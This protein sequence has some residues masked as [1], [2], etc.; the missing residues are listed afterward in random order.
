MSLNDLSFGLIRTNPK[1]SGNVKITVDSNQDIWLN[2]FNANPELSNNQFKKFRI[3]PTGFYPLDLYRFFLNGKVPASTVFETKQ[4]EISKGGKKDLVEQYDMFYTYGA[5][6]LNSKFYD[7]EVSLFAPLYLKKQIPKYFVIY[8]VPGPVTISN[9]TAVTLIEVGIEYKVLGSSNFTVTYNDVVYRSGDTFIGVTDI[10][11]FI[12]TSDNELY[13]LT[14]DDKVII[15]NENNYINDINDPSKLFDNVL[16]QGELVKTFDLRET[17]KIGQYIRNIINSPLYPIA[18]LEVNFGKDNLSHWHGISYKDGSFAKKGNFLYSELVK[19]TPLINFEEIITLGFERQ[20]LICA[21]LLNL[22][23]LFTDTTSDNWEINRYFGFYVDD[24]STG[25][26]LLDADKL[27]T[28]SLGINQLPIPKIFQ[29]IEPKFEGIFN[30]TN[31]DGIKVWANNLE[32]TFPTST[33]LSNPEFWW[34]KDN[35]NTFHNIK[36]ASTPVLDSTNYEF[37][38]TDKKLNIGQLTGFNRSVFDEKAFALKTKGRASVVLEIKESF[39]GYVNNSNYGEYIDLDVNYSLLRIMANPVPEWNVSQGGDHFVNLNF[40]VMP[41]DFPPVLANSNVVL[42]WFHPGTT[43]EETAK[44]I[45]NALNAYELKTFDAFAIGAKVYI[46]TKSL[47]SVGNTWFVN[48]NDKVDSLTKSGTKAIFTG[49]SDHTGSRVKIEKINPIIGDIFVKT[50][51]DWS[52]I[53]SVTPYLEEPI[54]INGV[55]QEF[56]DIE[57]YSILTITDVKETILIN[58]QNR[59]IGY[60]LWR[61]EVGIFSLYPIRDFDFDFHKSI[62]NKNLLHEIQKYYSVKPDTDGLLL[63]HIAYVVDGVDGDIIHYYGND[64]EPGQTFI[65]VQGVETGFS[66][67]SGT[68]TIRPAYYKNNP[69]SNE[70]KL[71]EFLGFSTLVD[72]FST[73]ETITSLAYKWF[74]GLLPNEYDYLKENTNKDLSLKSR[75]TPYINKWAFLDGTDIRNNPYRLNTNNVFGELNFSPSFVNQ[76]PNPNKFTHEWYYIDNLPIGVDKADLIDNLNYFE[77]KIDKTKLKQITSDYFSEYFRLTKMVGVD[78]HPQERWTEFRFNKASGFSETLF[79]GAKV[80]VKKIKNNKDIIK[81]DLSFQGYKFSV[82][83]TSKK[84]DT[85]IIEAPITYEVI[86]NKK[87]KTITIVITAILEDLR[88]CDDFIDY[89]N[90]EFT[91]IS[92]FNIIDG[93]PNLSWTPKSFLPKLDYLGLYTLA[94]KKAP[95]STSSG[96][97]YNVFDS[98]VSYAADI[99]LSFGLLLNKPVESE[100]VI[101]T[102]TIYDII[103]CDNDK[104]LINWGVNIYE[105]VRKITD[106]SQNF[107]FGDFVVPNMYKFVSTDVVF[108]NMSSIRNINTL[109]LKVLDSTYSSP[110]IGKNTLSRKT[111]STTPVKYIKGGLNFYSEIIKK[112]SFSFIQELLNNSSSL[113]TYSSIDENGNSIVSDF[114][115]N[116]LEPEIVSKTTTLTP[117]KDTDFPSELRILSN[118]GYDLEESNANN[119]V[120]R[121]SGYYQPIFKDL[122]LFKSKE[123]FEL[124][125]TSLNLTTNFGLINNFY[126]H[127]VS[128]RDIMKLAQNSKYDSVYPLINEISIDKKPLYIWQSNWDS[129]YHQ[130]Y[131]EAGVYTSQSGTRQMIEH[132][133]FLGSKIMKTPEKITINDFKSR[134]VT[135][136]ENFI[137][138]DLGDTEA[139]YTFT[140]ETIRIRVF[141]KKR[142]LRWMR[143]DGASNEFLKNILPEY[144]GGDLNSLNDDIDTY[145][146]TNIIELFNIDNIDMWVKSFKEVDNITLK[147][148][149]TEFNVIEKIQKGYKRKDNFNKNSI[150]KWVFEINYPIPTSNLTSIGIEFGIK[151][152]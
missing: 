93:S 57:K 108:K 39:V 65:K 53:L 62:Y 14:E 77:T 50:T 55:F 4:A 46:V 116:L 45:A 24:L 107:V 91:N 126:Y 109:L 90:D 150:S 148:V 36:P 68:P 106:A 32:G 120:L 124:E 140:N 136:I 7:E 20:S 27:K 141:A 18:P 151:R 35:T 16:K 89:Q 64:Y 152:I 130:F 17:S 87:F 67:S 112:L 104:T 70:K 44:G 6:A 49:G 86:Q 131:S 10:N 149:E 145:L 15:H 121:Y 30:Q 113:V 52:R 60:E 115:L 92:K 48:L 146:N 85:N 111:W 40:D 51:K 74:V 129:S 99:W 3:N 135:D 8:K 76:E 58:K 84:R 63:E 38:I 59:L 80:Q 54:F 21:N 147:M 118:I 72:K 139:I 96:V 31:D 88:F 42:N 98:E 114:I 125:R 127:K 81:D 100:T 143:E 102:N 71:I 47:G 122:F 22:E 110:S 1:L 82:V 66:I 132:K 69:T 83:L 2:S 144:S 134:E 73:E 137:E 123:G 128:N 23:F 37:T 103:I 56:K 11:S 43:P 95:F 79:R 117:I 78:I 133:S 41:I 19:E 94:D 12:L 33:D 142:I 138:S 61:N 25:S 34:L 119:F 105:E 97:N 28:E 75:V 13:T 9:L 26:F 29:S 5:E 101:S